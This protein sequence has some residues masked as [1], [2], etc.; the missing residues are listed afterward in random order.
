[1]RN[2][3]DIYND[4][5][6]ILLKIA[7]RGSCKIVMRAN[8]S[9]DSD[10]CEYEYDSVDNAGE[11]SWFTAEGRANMDMLGC[12]V[13]LQKWYVENKL[14]SGLPVWRG[15]QVKLNLDSMKISIDFSY[16]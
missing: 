6:A 9:Q 13:E 4:I 8:L 3:S 15:C 14:T 10:S 7:P 2:D 16:K 12:L 5:G 1:M 11:T